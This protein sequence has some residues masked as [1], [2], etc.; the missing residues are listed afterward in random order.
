MEGDMTMERLA[1]FLRSAAGRVVVDKTGLAGSYRLTLT[2]DRMATLRGPDTAPA[3]DA[4]LSVFTAVQEQLGLK[5]ESSKTTRELLIIDR[6]E[7]PNEN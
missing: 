4:P 1:G 2:Y 3:A 6:L 5:L 7:R